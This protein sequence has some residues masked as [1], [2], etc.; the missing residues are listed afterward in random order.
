MLAFQFLVGVTARDWWPETRPGLDK[1][2]VPGFPT[3][4]ET[5]RGR[6]RLRWFNVRPQSGIVP[7]LIGSCSGC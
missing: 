3:T 4:N 5:T 1:G 2:A 6:E 7:S